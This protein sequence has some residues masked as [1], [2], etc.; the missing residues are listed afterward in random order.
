VL[1]KRSG[2]S[3]AGTSSGPNKNQV[4]MTGANGMQSQANANNML[5]D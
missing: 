1:K 5:L 2:T 4:M 3:H